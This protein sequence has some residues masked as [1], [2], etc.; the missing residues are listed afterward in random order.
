MGC[1]TKVSL[2]QGENRRCQN[3]I[4]PQCHEGKCRCIDGEQESEGVLAWSEFSLCS[5][6]YHKVERFYEIKQRVRIIHTGK[7]R[8][9]LLKT[10]T[11]AFNWK[12]PPPEVLILLLDISSMC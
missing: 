5:D 2:S 12:I 11:T 6:T 9:N 10:H 7:G 4:N 1:G 8:H 3:G